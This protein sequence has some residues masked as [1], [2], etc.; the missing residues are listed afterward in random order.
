M[1]RK[2]IFCSIVLLAGC[3]VGMAQQDP[4]ATPP[5][6]SGTVAATVNGE[7][8]TQGELGAAAALNRIFQ[9]VLSEFPNFGQILLTTPEGE[10]LLRVYQLKVL[11]QLIDERLWVQEA[12]ARGIEVDESTVASQVEAQLRQIMEQNQLTLEE[13]EEILQQQ[14]SSL[15]EYKANLGQGF[16]ERLMVQGLYK[17]VT[18]QVSVGD[19]EVAAYYE[20]HKEDYASEDGTIS[21]LSDVRDEIHAALLPQAQ[22]DTWQAWFGHEKEEAKIEI[23]F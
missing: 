1:Q 3:I 8:I 22:A 14:G 19:E 15:D 7:I 6:G 17:E 23:L 2:L 11:E 13:V 20:T 18:A 5:D 9:L 4:S 12:L 16:R 21:P 10:A